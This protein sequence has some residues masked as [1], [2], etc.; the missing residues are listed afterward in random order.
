MLAKWGH[1]Q[2]PMGTGRQASEDM[3]NRRIISEVTLA[4]D[5]ENN[6]FIAF[7]VEHYNERT[8]STTSAVKKTITSQVAE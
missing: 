1:A 6:E 2:T 5:N 3:A 4:A 8:L 7:C